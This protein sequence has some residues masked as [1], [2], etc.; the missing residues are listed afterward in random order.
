MAKMREYLEAWSGH[1]ASHQFSIQDLE[2]YHGLGGER[3]WRM[4]RIL[5]A[6]TFQLWWPVAQEPAGGWPRDRIVPRQAALFILQALVL[7]DAASPSEAAALAAEEAVAAGAA[8]RTRVA[9]AAPLA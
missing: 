6:T 5:L 9:A 7:N 1:G 2:T 3:V 4:F 8:K